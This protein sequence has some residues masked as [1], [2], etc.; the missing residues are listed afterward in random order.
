MN[1]EVQP[2]GRAGE[3][4]L[5]DPN[6]GNMQCKAHDLNLEPFCDGTF[7]PPWCF[8][9]WCY[10]DPSNCD[11]TAVRSKYFKDTVVYYSYGACG[12]SNSWRNT[13]KRTR[14]LRRQHL[15][16]VVLVMLHH[17]A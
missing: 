2:Q 9:K 5:Y 15:V 17:R 6:Y 11:K 1:I 4:F 14:M 8:A 12:R 7:P 13:R 16:A 3:K 10:V